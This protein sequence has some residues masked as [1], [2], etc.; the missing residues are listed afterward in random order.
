MHGNAY[1]CFYDRSSLF[2]LCHNV[3][4]AKKLAA[5]LRYDK[6]MNCEYFCLKL[7]MFVKRILLRYPTTHNTSIFT[8]DKE[9]STCYSTVNNINLYANIV[10]DKL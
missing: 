4:Y 5:V 7:E 1:S 9:K 6:I 8:D 3:D 10:L 2:L